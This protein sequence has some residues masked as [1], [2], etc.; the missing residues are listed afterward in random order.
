MTWSSSRCPRTGARTTGKSPVVHA[1]ATFCCATYVALSLLFF[2]YPLAE[3]RQVWAI[4][5]WRLGF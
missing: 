4:F 1:L 3:L 2:A 5:M